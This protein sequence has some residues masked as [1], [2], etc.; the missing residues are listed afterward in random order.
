V[1]EQEG[2]RRSRVAMQEA[3]LILLL[4]DASRPLDANDRELLAQAPK[5]KTI[6]IW[7]KI[8]LGAFDASISPI[9]IERLCL[10][11]FWQK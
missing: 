2:I 4:L 1:V 11:H 8:D 3:D 9:G 5:E 6:L 10:H 7:N